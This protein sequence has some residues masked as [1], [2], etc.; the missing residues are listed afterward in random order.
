MLKEFTDCLY[1]LFVR[2]NIELCESLRIM[3]GKPKKDK[4]SKAAMY[5]LGLLE[6]G[7]LFSNALKTC[8]F[9]EFDK[10]YISFILL[11]EK[12]GYFIL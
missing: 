8:A 6:N 11:A 1:E 3:S 2:Q 10:V 9:I 4:I 12:N 7:T 5:I